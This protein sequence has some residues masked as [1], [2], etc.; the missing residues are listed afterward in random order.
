MI[1]QGIRTP[2]GSAHAYVQYHHYSL[3][4]ISLIDKVSEILTFGNPFQS[5]KSQNV[6]G[7]VAKEYYLSVW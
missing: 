2:S 4:W 5:V 1:F 7:D 3:L 6:G